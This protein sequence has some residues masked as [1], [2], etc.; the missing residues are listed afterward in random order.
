MGDPDVPGQPRRPQSHQPLVSAGLGG[1]IAV[2][3]Q[4]EQRDGHPHRECLG[5]HCDA[6]GGDHDG[7]G[8]GEHAEIGVGG[9]AGAPA[10]QP[11][12]GQRIRQRLCR[13]GVGAGTGCQQQGAIGIGV[14]GHGGRQLAP[15]RG[16]QRIRPAVAADQHDGT[17]RRERREGSVPRGALQRQPRG[18]HAVQRGGV[19]QH[20]RRRRHA[21][22]GRRDQQVEVARAC[23]GAA[24]EH[25][26]GLAAGGPSHPARDRFVAGA[27][28]DQQIRPGRR[29]GLPRRGGDAPHAHGAQQREWASEAGVLEA[30]GDDLPAQRPVQ[31]LRQTDDL[32]GLPG[33]IALHCPN[34]QIQLHEEILK[35][36]RNKV[37][38]CGVAW[39]H[40][41]AV[42]AGGGAVPLDRRE[43]YVIRRLKRTVTAV[44]QQLLNLGERGREVFET[45]AGSQGHGGNASWQDR[46]LECRWAGTHRPLQKLAGEPGRRTGSHD[47]KEVGLLDQKEVGAGPKRSRCWTKKKSDCWTRTKDAA[48]NAANVVSRLGCF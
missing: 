13:G 7:V 42:R 35:K 34:G 8:P 3:R 28:D 48:C 30:L 14:R 41:L 16:A 23:P 47:R 39:Q 10:I 2:C 31:A 44:L 45:N 24:D 37:E 29:Q 6:V 26:S 20:V 27:S 40:A 22:L 32:A 5:E 12:V 33:A 18:V 4:V 1:G 36:Y 46:W 25:D 17:G 21:V 9:V 19:F 43:K 38:G 15:R 11:R